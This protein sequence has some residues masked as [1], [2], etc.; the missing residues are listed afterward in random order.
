MRDF[1]KALEIANLKVVFED[2]RFSSKL[3]VK[4]ISKSGLPKKKRQEKG[5]IDEAAAILILESY[6]ARQVNLSTSNDG[7]I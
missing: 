7:Y 3:A 2:E 5:R 4:N 1:A 6:L